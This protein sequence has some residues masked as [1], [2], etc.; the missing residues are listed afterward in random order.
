[1]I[2]DPDEE[3]NVGLKGG[4]CGSDTGHGT[5][6]GDRVFDRFKGTSSDTFSDFCCFSRWTSLGQQEKEA[7]SRAL[8]FSSCLDGEG[9][10]FLADGS[11]CCPGDD[12]VLLFRLGTPHCLVLFGM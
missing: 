1:M 7:G 3:K 5:R 8:L 4:D 6:G 10:D 9:N 2:L 11:D 12:D